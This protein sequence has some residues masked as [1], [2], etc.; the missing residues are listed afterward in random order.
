MELVSRCWITKRM[1]VALVFLVLCIF[2]P[3]YNYYVND[4]IQYNLGMGSVSALSYMILAII[5]LYAY[6]YITKI[7]KWL[8]VLMVVIVIYLIISYLVYPEIKEAFISKDYNPL[9]SVLLFIPLMGFPMMVY[10]NYLNKKIYYIVELCRIPSLGLIVLAIIDYYWTV[11]VNGHYFDVN[12]MAFSYYMLPAVCFSFCYGIQKRNLIDIIGSVIGLM[13]IFVVGSRGCFLCGI[14]FFAIVSIKRY[15][16]S[17][18]KILIYLVS[19][20]VMFFLASYFLPSFS[21]K[22]MFYMEEHGASSRTLLKISDGTLDESDSRISIYKIMLKSIEEQPLG[23]G[24]MGDRYILNQHGNQGYAHSIIYEFLVDYGIFIGP[25]L[26][27]V[28]TV[29]LFMKYKFYYK[30]D[31]YYVYAVFMTIG[32]IK[33]FFTSSY[34]GEPFFWGLVG[35]LYKK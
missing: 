21:D 9:T 33:L 12:Y 15:S 32:V 10:T 7:N 16:F 14:I 26:L 1:K 20:V 5:G 25:V 4:I 3:S 19:I 35:M 28:F 23:Y 8:T 11:L 2:I 22:V 29:S 30:N 34:L 24:P 27:I 31:V 13:V 17:V 18:G 6:S